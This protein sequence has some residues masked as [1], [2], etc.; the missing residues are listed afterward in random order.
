MLHK[1]YLLIGCESQRLLERAESRRIRTRT[2][3]LGGQRLSWRRIIIDLAP[4][5]GLRRR[6]QTRALFF[7]S[8]FRLVSLAGQRARRNLAPD[9]AAARELCNLAEEQSRSCTSCRCVS[10]KVCVCW[11]GFC[12]GRGQTC[13]VQFSS[14][15][16]H[17][18]YAP[19]R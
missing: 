12:V 14:C 5:F 7:L 8:F 16:C 18:A 13:T 3:R 15:E 9:T 1:S 4:R 2:R 11:A 17:F 10:S 6:R 19:P